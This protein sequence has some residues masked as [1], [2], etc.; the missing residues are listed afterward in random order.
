MKHYV[1]FEGCDYTGKTTYAKAFTDFIN[2]EVPGKA[3][4]TKEPGSP[5]S[6]TCV[7]IRELIINAKNIQNPETYSGLFF[8][9]NFE[10][11]NSF[12]IPLMNR[13][14]IV[15]SDRSVISDYAYRPNLQVDIREYNLNKFKSLS[16]LVV[17]CR[18]SETIIKERYLRR[19][20]TNEFERIN[21]MNKIDPINKAYQKFFY[22]N[23]DL[24][25]IEWFSSNDNGYDQRVL[26]NKIL[27]Y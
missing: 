10:H 27:E 6:K 25:V 8:A 17:W 11:I 7:S 1:V 13:L 16:P 2:K 21:V 19:K 12:V 15:V 26:F 20:D 14:M 3:I 23:Q 24:D 9:D 22:E 18:A 4:Y 5:L